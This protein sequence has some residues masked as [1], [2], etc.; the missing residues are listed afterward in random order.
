MVRRLVVVALVLVAIVA[1]PVAAAG[2]PA[3]QDADAGPGAAPAP[4][5]LQTGPE[6]NKGYAASTGDDIVRTMAFSL[7]PSE[8][9]S[10]DVE[11]AYE[12]PG[13]VVELRTSVPTGA[14]VEA[15]VG[16]EPDD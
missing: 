11:L 9:G 4:A 8:P 1:Q 10:V 7:T 6:A 12:I 14:T 3:T 2:G 13:T 15:V 16:F 5:A